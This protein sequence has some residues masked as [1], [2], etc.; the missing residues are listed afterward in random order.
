MTVYPSKQP[1]LITLFIA[2]V[3]NDL[4]TGNFPV[5]EI[6]V[7]IIQYFSSINWH[8]GHTWHTGKLNRW[9]AFQDVQMLYAIVGSQNG[10]EFSLCEYSRALLWSGQ[11]FPTDRKAPTVW[12]SVFVSVFHSSVHTEVLWSPSKPREAGLV[13]SSGRALSGYWKAPLKLIIQAVK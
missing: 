5:A 9:F 6:T 11:G 10:L 2:P 3:V 7:V 1:L 4:T 13:S 12:K 8:R